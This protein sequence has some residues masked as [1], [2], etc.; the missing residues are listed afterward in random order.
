MPS[1]YPY[2]FDLWASISTNTVKDKLFVQSNVER[3]SC[4]EEASD[5]LDAALLI[6]LPLLQLLG[7]SLRLKAELILCRFSQGDENS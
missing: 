5:N 7:L 4:I 2:W 6:I 3:L 1:L